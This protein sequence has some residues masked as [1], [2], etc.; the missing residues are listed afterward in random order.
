MPKVSAMTEATTLDGTEEALIIQSST[1]KRAGIDT[2]FS[3]SN[4]KWQG[5][6]LP[7]SSGWVGTAGQP[8]TSTSWDGDAY[9]TTSKTQIDLSTV[10]GVPA[11]IKAI[12][13][14]IAAR[15]SG[16]AASSSHYYGLSPNNTADIVALD[17]SSRGLP[18]DYW[19]GEYGIVPCN[20]SG[21]VYYQC[22]A[23]GASTLDVI[24]QIW[25]YL[26]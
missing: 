24:V 4:S 3:S 21:D 23:T 19:T 5:W 26:L 15:D 2:M 6:V 22:A 18:N 10:F 8:L 1:S 25:G 17:V 20:A 13:V 11:G 14:R 9:S 7:Y 12:L 16:S